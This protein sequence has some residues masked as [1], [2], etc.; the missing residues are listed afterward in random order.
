MTIRLGAR[1]YEFAGFGEPEAARER[2]ADNL[3]ACD[4]STPDGALHTWLFVLRLRRATC[5]YS[6]LLLCAMSQEDV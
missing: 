2:K 1:I 5:M 6:N 3:Y 4:R